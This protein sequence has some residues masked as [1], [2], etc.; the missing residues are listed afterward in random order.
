MSACPTQHLRSSRQSSVWALNSSGRCPAFRPAEPRG[1]LYKVDQ[2]GE[3]GEGANSVILV[4]H[5][6]GHQTRPEC[7]TRPRIQGVGVGRVIWPRKKSHNSCTGFI[8]KGWPRAPLWFALWLN[9]LTTYYVSGST[10]DNP[11]SPAFMK[12][13]QMDTN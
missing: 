10:L 2:T 5:P 3:L 4:S 11:Q 13:K 7:R 6:Q 12:D 9:L 8:L 1:N